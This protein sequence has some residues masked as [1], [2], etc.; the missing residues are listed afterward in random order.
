MS[1]MPLTRQAIFDRDRRRCV[2]CGAAERD[3]ARLSVDH[4]EPRMLGGDDSDGNVVTACR[5]CNREKG[6]HAAW[7]YLAAR[8]G[9]R[10][11]FLEH[12]TYVWPRLRD[13][14]VEAAAKRR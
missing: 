8:D 11:H 10:A 7:S 5:D 12:A 3:G 14:I 2:Y 9:K 4:V 1:R 13:A 6:H